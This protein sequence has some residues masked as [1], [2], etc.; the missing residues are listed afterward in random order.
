MLVADAKCAKTL[1]GLTKEQLGRPVETVAAGDITGLRL[2]PFR[3]VG[4]S[5]GMLLAIRLDHVR[6]GTKWGSAVVAFAPEG[7]G[8]GNSYRALMGGTL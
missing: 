5:A 2:M 6:I 7:L 1:L 8:E 3:T 4:R